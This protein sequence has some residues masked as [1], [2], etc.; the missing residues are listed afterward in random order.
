MSNHSDRIS[1][2]L[3]FVTMLSGFPVLLTIFSETPFWNPHLQ[4]CNVSVPQHSNLYLPYFFLWSLIFTELNYSHDLNCWLLNLYFYP[5]SCPWI[6]ESFSH[7]AVCL[8]IIWMFLKR[9]TLDIQ[10]ADTTIIF[11]SDLN[12]LLLFSL[13]QLME[14]LS[15][16]IQNRR[17]LSYPWCLHFA[18]PYTFS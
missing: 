4:L 9:K 18:S 6:S 2:A 12:L 3:I 10:M 17:L 11:P 7:A 8:A 5:R 13:S 15:S 14:P 1:A 16:I